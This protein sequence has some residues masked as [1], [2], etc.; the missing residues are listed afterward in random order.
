[1]ILVDLDTKHFQKTTIHLR[2]CFITEDILLIALYGENVCLLLLFIV[3]STRNNLPI[4]KRFSNTA[5][6]SQA[7]QFMQSTNILQSV[8]NCYTVPKKITTIQMAQQFGFY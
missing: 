7:I 1:M 6:I 5:I 4:L 3:I 2:P 8:L